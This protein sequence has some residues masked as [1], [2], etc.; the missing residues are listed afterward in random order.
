MG[1][2]DFIN[3]FNR[4]MDVVDEAVVDKDMKIKLQNE[5]EQLKQ[6]VYIA[7]LNT[8]TIPWVDGVHKLGRQGL[9]LLTLLIGAWL[10]H[11]HPELDMGTLM[12]IAAPTG[13]YNL[14]KKEGRK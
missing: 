1:I 4:I 8:K 14:A 7:E 2:L 3:P 13:L 6:Q 10:I 9:S 12:A 5:L 11:K